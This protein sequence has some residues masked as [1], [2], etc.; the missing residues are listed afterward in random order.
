MRFLSVCSGIE[1][2]SVAL[3]PLGWECVGVS[4]IEPFPC[5]VLHHRHGAGRPAFMPANTRPSTLKAIRALP[6]GG[7]IP[8]FG[9][10]TRFRE[11]SDVP[12][13]DVL[14]GGTPCQSFS[15]AGLRE[16]L[17]DPRGNLALTFLAIA[18][19]FQPSWVGW[20]NVPGVL[21]SNDG[22]DFAAFIGGLVQ[23][24]YGVAW[25]VLD[26]QFVRVDGY[27]R[28]VPQRR[29][30]VFVVGCLGDWRRAAAVL[31]ERESL[32]GDPAPRRQAGQGTAAGAGNG[33]GGDGRWPAA[34]ASTLNAA[35]GEKLGLE[36]QH[37]LSGA[38][39]FVPGHQAV[40]HTLRAEGFDAS[41]DGTGRQNQVLASE[42]YTLAIR[43]RADGRDG[44]G[45]GAV[46]VGFNITPSNSNKDYSAR[47]AGA[48]M[49]LTQQ[50]GAAPSARGGSVIAYT[51]AHAA[52][53]ALG[54]NTRQDPVPSLE[55]AGPIDTDGTTQ[56]D[57]LRTGVRRLT[58]RECERLQGFPDDYTA[59]PV[60]DKPAADGPRYRALGNSMAVNVM[61]WIGRRIELVED[62]AR[63]IAAETHTAT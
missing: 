62:V 44:M 51:P 32:R 3:E 34:V 9:D 20:E 56:A 19:R 59:V 33:F 21:S 4:E 11:W 60:G 23:L 26:A 42:P 10:M 13:F 16:G 55:C 6:E 31:V 2:A 30:R 38:P 37:A 41:E 14:I 1:A 8:N 15:V 28:A 52:T 35:F 58:P 27:A 43:G 5:H 49:A 48:A 47:P 57:S 45:V 18:E 54:F 46:A 12:A 36:D 22:R 29:N 24:G 63:E 50:A 61:R 40:A 53:L 25:R 7:R 39:L 17:A